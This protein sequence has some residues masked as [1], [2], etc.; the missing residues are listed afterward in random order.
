MRDTDSQ[1]GGWCLPTACCDEASS[2]EPLDQPMCPGWDKINHVQIVLETCPTRGAEANKFDSTHFRDTPP[3]YRELN[4][5]GRVW[6]QDLQPK[7]H[8]LPLLRHLHTGDGAAACTKINRIAVRVKQV[9][10]DLHRNYGHGPSVLSMLFLGHQRVSTS[11]MNLFVSLVKSAARHSPPRPYYSLQPILEFPARDVSRLI[12]EDILILSLRLCSIHRHISIPDHILWPFM[13]I[14][15][16]R[17]P[18]A[19]PHHD[20]LSDINWLFEFRKNTLGNV[21]RVARTGNLVD[22]QSK[23]VAAVAADHVAF[24]HAGLKPFGRMPQ[25]GIARLVPEAVVD[26]FESIQIDEQNG[27]LR[28]L[29]GAVALDGARDLLEELRPI[30]QAG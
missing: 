2:A 19:R 16:Q 28:V 12:A 13:Q 23:L 11:F 26:G 1:V 7:V 9:A 14:D 8:V 18:D 15:T 24:S 4:L 22:E 17:N 20:E 29:V 10:Y 25:H 27:E 6:L 21:D 5:D 30:G 3:D